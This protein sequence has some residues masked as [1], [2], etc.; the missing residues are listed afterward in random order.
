MHWPK[1][2]T[3]CI[4][5]YGRRQQ[6]N[7]GLSRRSAASAEVSLQRS[8]TQLRMQLSVA[9]YGSTTLNGAERMAN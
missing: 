6:G 4:E 8:H 5:P 2:A 9:E 1:S 7:T 3:P